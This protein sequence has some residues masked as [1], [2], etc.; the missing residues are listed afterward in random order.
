MNQLVKP[1]FSTVY[2]LGSTITNGTRRQ[3]VVMVTDSDGVYG[4][5]PNAQT[6]PNT[7]L[8]WSRKDHAQ[9]ICAAYN[10]CRLLGREWYVI[11]RRTMVTTPQGWDHV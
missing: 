3:T 11:S 10:C 9:E 8:S 6:L 7:V 4:Y 5:V 1:K 2:V